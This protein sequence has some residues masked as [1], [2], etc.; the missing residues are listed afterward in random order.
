MTVRSL[1][2]QRAAER[3]GADGETR[4]SQLSVFYS[5]NCRIDINGV[6]RMR[7]DIEKKLTENSVKP[8]SPDARIWIDAYS[9][10]VTSDPDVSVEAVSSREDYTASAKVSVTAT[11]GDYF[12]FHPLE[13]LS[14]YYYSD[15]D[16]MQ[17]RVILDENLAW[18]LFGSDNVEGMTVLIGEKRFYVAGVVKTDGSKTGKYVY[19][20]KPRIYMSYAGYESILGASLSVDCYEAVLPDPVTGLAEKIVTDVV[21]PEEER[22]VK[23]VNNSGRFSVK[24][25][26]EIAFDGGTRAAASVPMA[27]PF[28][29][30][31]ARITEEK[32]A[33]LLVWAA[34]M[35]FV[36]LLTL[37][38]FAVKL[39]RKRKVI[40]HK[41]AVKIKETAENILIRIKA[42]KK[43]G[44]KS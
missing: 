1:P 22:A 11:G 6:Y 13:L 12:F 43:R 30:N 27:Y 16:L 39:Y 4:Y 31:A 29:E 42:A 7:S 21:S 3:W 10:E 2:P 25:L 40:L 41:A 5:G 17:D 33:V 19:G 23:I 20:S 35:L 37:L 44:G 18:Q 9:S 15:S 8:V 14:G 36:P 38:Y 28:W 32:A 34:A 26:L 24:R